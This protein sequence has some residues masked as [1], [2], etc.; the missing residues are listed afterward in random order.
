MLI[1]L[2]MIIIVKLWFN[3]SRSES[4]RRR[5]RINVELNGVW[6]IHWL[7]VQILP[8]QFNELKIQD[9]QILIA[10]FVKQS[11]NWICKSNLYLSVVREMIRL[12]FTIIISMFSMIADVIVHILGNLSTVLVFKIK[13]GA[14]RKIDW[15]WR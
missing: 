2:G 1:A 3:L 6:I 11:F 13:L 5:N 15:A 4:W 14:A 9:F 12:G 7:H 8:D 10:I